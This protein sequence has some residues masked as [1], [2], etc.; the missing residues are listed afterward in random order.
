MFYLLI[1]LRAFVPVALSQSVTAVQPMTGLVL[2][3]DEA[4]DR[5][6]AYGKSIALEFS[7]CLPCDVVTGKSVD[8]TILYDWTKFEA[9]L[10]GVASRGHQAVVRFRYEYPN[11]E[12]ING[13]SGATAVPAYIKAMSGYTETYSKN[14]GGDGPTYYA[15]W[16]NAE[17]QW[18]TKQFYTDLA[19]RYGRDPRI[20]FLEVGFGHWSEYH[21]YGTSL[22]LGKNFPSKQYQR[23]FFQHMDTIMPIPWLVSIDV[24]DDEYSPVADDANLMACSFGLFDDSFMHK[25]H[26]IG[27]RDGYNE[28][29]WR[30]V[31]SENNTSNLTRWKTGVC[32]G[33]ISYYSDRD[34]KEFLN[35]SGLYGVT[36]EQASS[37]YHITFMIAN[38][39]PRGSYGTAQRFREASMAVGYRFRVTSLSTNGDSTCVSLTNEGIAP[40][41]RDAYLTIGNV[42]DSTSL[43]SL[44]PGDTMTV[45]IPGDVRVSPLTITSPHIL[46]SQTIGFAADLEGQKTDMEGFYGLEKRAQ[47]GATKLLK[48]GTLW[49]IRGGDMYRIMG[50]R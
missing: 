17:L 23:E 34:Q 2:W 18:F 27:S 29:N 48:D 16:S 42:S 22:Q 25:D 46:P 24:A 28:E 12:K 21:I 1:L 8:G 32:G 38:D 44:L 13:V 30:L 6:A 10:N 36:W 26:E 3:P 45:T 41:Y 39:A 5:H 49:V 33:E 19:A 11:G 43:V 14:P 4:E 15:D 35:P 47:K 31:G 20:A 9:F 37:K 40:I 7:Y 50:N